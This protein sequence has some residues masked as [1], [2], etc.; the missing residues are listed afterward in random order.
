[1][2]VPQMGRRGCRSNRPTV[3]ATPLSR[4]RLSGLCA[5]DRAAVDT[6]QFVL[7]IGY[8]VQLCP[9]H[10]GVV[11]SG[12]FVPGMYAFAFSPP[13]DGAAD[14]RKL[15]LGF[16]RV[17]HLRPHMM[18]VR[19]PGVG[20]SCSLLPPCVG[21]CFSCPRLRCCGQSR[22]VSRAHALAPFG[23]VRSWK[24]SVLSI[25]TIRHGCPAPGKTHA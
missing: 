13:R 16:V 12:E 22:S 5:P 25:P 14:A 17:S 4:L 21:G 6:G 11:D 15:V 2:R 10:D 23:V 8:G 9:P 3:P 1:M 20:S 7:T 18:L 19:M 24:R